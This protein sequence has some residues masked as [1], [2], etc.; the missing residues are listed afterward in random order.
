MLEL[1]GQMTQRVLR[2]ADGKRRET[3]VPR[4]GIGVVWPHTQP[5][6]TMCAA[7]VCLVLQGDK[8]MLVGDKTLRYEAGSCFA[9]LIELPSKRWIFGTTNDKPYVATSLRLDHDLMSSV[10]ADLPSP[11]V[12][13]AVAGFSVQPVSRGLIEAWD[14]HLALLDTPEDIAFLAP[15]RERELLYRLLES[16]HG[17]MLRQIARAEGQLARIRRAI[18][19]MRDHFSEP[20]DIATLAEIAGMS[21]ASFNRHFRAATSTSPLQYQKTLRLQEARRLLSTNA[22]ATRAAYAVGYESTSQFSREYSRLFGRPPKQDAAFHRG[23]M[24]ELSSVL[25]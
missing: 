15:L 10:L 7:G 22:D 19:W 14:R 25:I 18:D 17:P 11:A 13:K 16:P 21:V 23:K 9:S 8:Q 3:R 5:A 24:S 12:G 6:T 4:L 1:L 2:H 20:L